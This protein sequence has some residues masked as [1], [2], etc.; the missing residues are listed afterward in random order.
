MQVKQIV[1]T[2]QDFACGREKLSDTTVLSAVILFAAASFLLTLFLPS[3]GEEGVY[4]NI[5]L[6]MLY[7]ND[8]LVPR[9][10]GVHY[11]RPPLFNWLMMVFTSWFGPTK[12]VLA[13]RIVNMLSTLGS[14]GLLVWFVRRIFPEKQF[15]L[16]TG[17]IYLSGDL[18]FRRG[19]LAY[20]DS[21]FSLCIFSSMVCLWMA[22]EYKQQKWF[23]GAVLSL[24]GGFLAK[25]HTVYIFYA[26]AGLVLI[27]RHPNRK[28]IFTPM[29][30]VLHLAALIFPLYWTVYINKGYGGMNTT[31][32]QSQSF[33]EW[34]GFFAYAYRIIISYPLDVFYRF[35]PS[36][37]IALLMWYKMRSTQKPSAQHSAIT[38]VFWIVF[39]NLLPYWLVPASNIRYILPLYPMIS[40]LIAYV[41]WQSGNPTRRFA[42]SCLLVTLVLKYALAILWFPYEHNVYRGNALA[43][44]TDILQRTKDENLYINDSTSSGLRVAVELNKARYSKAP[45]TAPP[46]NFHGYLLADSNNPVYGSLVH[47]YNLRSNKIYLF[48]SAGSE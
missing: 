7:N 27:W 35:L 21:L 25:I 38:I 33:L 47:I 1:P 5:T 8:Y 9:L 11:S 4:T 26:I 37:L 36:S 12:V 48:F 32:S 13:A 34:P 6:E 2:F 24:C 31:W 43:I 19:W 10:Y 42:V 22:L 16:L 44:A 23:L 18:L 40:L 39:L 45:L 46:S 20:A 41:I 17:A 14:A 30:W 29:S 15:A 3:V 28:F